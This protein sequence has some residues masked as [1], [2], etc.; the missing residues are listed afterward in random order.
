[1]LDEIPAADIPWSEK[2]D[3]AIWRGA[4]TGMKR[5][6]FRV[7]QSVKAGANNA[8]IKRDLCMN[9]QRCKLVYEH[10]TSSL[11]NASLVGV[12]A[13]HTHNAFSAPVVPNILD[14]VRLFGPRAS[15][16]DLLRYKAIIMLEGN[17]ISSGLKWALYSNSVVLAQNPTYT[18]WAMEEELQPWVH[19]VPIADDL[20]DV[21]EKARWVAEH[22]EQ[23]QEIARSG[24]LWISDLVYHPDAQA[25]EDAIF[26]ETF[27]RYKQ[28]FAY[29]PALTAESML[30]MDTMDES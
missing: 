13:T 10:A 29:N 15:Y 9:M 6:G 3:G 2:L 16:H 28:H 22:D 1:M 5:N 17:D 24:S 30:S 19:Y 25:D 8:N 7:V 21:E 18:S 23:A 26:D 4:L 14:G 20:S 11:I 12:A 27:R